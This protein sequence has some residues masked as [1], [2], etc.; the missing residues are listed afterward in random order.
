MCGGKVK[1]S[2]K[3]GGYA[4]RK[5]KMDIFFKTNVGGKIFC[6]YIC[7]PVAQVM[8]ILLAYGVYLR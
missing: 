4:G 1:K 5:R 7:P 8:G 2:Q 3:P 6:F